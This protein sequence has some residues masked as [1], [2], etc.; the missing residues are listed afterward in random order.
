MVAT[1]LRNK[2]KK[3]RK[4]RLLHLLR[5]LNSKEFFWLEVILKHKVFYFLKD[6]QTCF[7]FGNA[8]FNG[9]FYT[10]FFGLRKQGSGF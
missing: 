9:Y 1:I 4:T 10:T 3:I 2:A 5:L 8:S 7:S 6:F